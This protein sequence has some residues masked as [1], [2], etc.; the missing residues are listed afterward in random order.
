MEKIDYKRDLP[1]QK[2]ISKTLK[3]LINFICNKLC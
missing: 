3:I 2:K 1:L